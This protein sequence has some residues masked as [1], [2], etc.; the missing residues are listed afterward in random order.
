MSNFQYCQPAQN[1]SPKTCPNL[2]FCSIKMAYRAAKTLSLVS[3]L[4]TKGQL[5]SKCLFG[6][7]NFFQNERKQVNLRFHSSKV[8]FVHSFF[9]RNIGLKKLFWLCLTFRFFWRSLDIVPKSLITCLLDWVDTFAPM[10]SYLCSSFLIL[11]L[12]FW[13]K[14]GMKNIM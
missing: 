11:V 12:Q 3:L 6:V 1:E 5:I 8:E 7:F 10:H 14:L 9:G 4:L 2:K 13:G